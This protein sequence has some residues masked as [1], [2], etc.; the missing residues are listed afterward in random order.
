MNI[1]RPI[2]RKYC[3]NCNRMAL[4]SSANRF[5]IRSI[6]EIRKRARRLS[7]RFL[8]FLYGVSHPQHTWSKKN[9]R[10]FAE[11]W[12]KKSPHRKCDL[13]LSMNMHTSSSLNCLTKTIDPLDF[14]ANFSALLLFLSSLYFTH[15]KKGYFDRGCR[16]SLSKGRGINEMKLMWSSQL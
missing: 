2:K 8:S 7:V 15:M 16:S 12:K 14:L 1:G 4:L 6:V 5:P 10:A 11:K 3:F 9:G 13:A